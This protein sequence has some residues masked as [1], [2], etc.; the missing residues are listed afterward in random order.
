MTVLYLAIAWLSGIYLDSLLR[1][2]GWVLGLATVLPIAMSLLWWREWRV[3]LGGLCVLFLLLGALRYDVALPHFDE[4][5]LAY[6]NGRGEVTVIGVVADE[7]EVRDRYVNLRVGARY[8]ELEGQGRE[9]KGLALLR[10]PRYP[11][12]AYGDQLQ[13]EA[14]LETPPEFEDFSYR[15]Y[16]A[17]QG[18]HSMVRFGQITRLSQGHGDP[19]HRTVYAL[20]GRLQATIAHL[21]PEPSASLLT[22]ILL[23]I[24]TGIPASLMEDFNK[25]STTHIIAISGFNVAVLAGAIGLL[26]RRFLGIYRSALVSIVAIIVYTILVGADAAVVRAA[27]MGGLSLLA[28]IA[29]RRA[30]A[31]ASLALAAFLMTLWNP[32]LLWDIGFQLSF[33]ATLGLVLLVPPLEARLEGLLSRLLS[34]ERA[35]GM[36]RLLS[37]P[38]IV[39]LA[40]Q[41]AVWPLTIYYFHRFSLISPL[42]NFLIIPA[43]PGVMMIGG[44]ATLAGFFHPYLGQPIAWVAWL[45]LAY[46][47]TVVELTARLP[48]TSLELG[49]FGAG[50]LGLCYASLGGI[51]LVVTQGRAGLRKVWERFSLGLSTKL[52]IGGLGLLVILAWIAALQMPDG[53]LH[54]VFFDV[55]QGDAIFVQCP[56]GRQIL[57][58]GGPSPS[59]LVSRLGR[60]MPFWDRSLDVVILTHPQEDHLAGLV[61]MLARYEVEQVVD[62]GQ[63]CDMAICEAWQELVEEKGIAYRRAEAGMRID[64]GG[65]VQLDILHPPSRL[66]ANTTSDTNNNSVVARL[67]YRRFS[68]LLTGDVAHEGEE[69]LVASG[70]PL[71]SLVLKVPHH[72]ADTSLTLRFLQ[73]VNPQLAVISV[74]ADNR[75]GHPAE[76]TVEKLQ[77]IPTYRTDQQGSIEV[78]SDGQRY[79]VGTER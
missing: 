14:E 23:G 51:M 77:A 33:A 75:F 58:D 4:S 38:L 64:V 5:T 56:D 55:G 21:F 16:L 72:G 67:S 41:L 31:L 60:E 69:A 30:Y 15:D 22:G 49:H 25:T 2:P 70:Q 13:I 74:G 20:K 39:T 76:V 36:V 1:V 71:T 26:T 53:R 37:E 59:A 43:Q 35:K 63:A 27:I 61:E 62:S 34:K 24:E 40:A 45:F 57:V 68:L 52:A 28:I 17:R 11:S 18:I 9:I 7:P 6:Y 65:S 78:I 10:A 32:L 42:S 19:F 79:W 8:L 50:P 47:I 73:A 66:L 3:K 46:T 29:G 12:Y 44:M 54:V 48:F